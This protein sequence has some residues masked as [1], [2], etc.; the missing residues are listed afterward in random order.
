MEQERIIVVSTDT[1]YLDG[2]ESKLKKSVKREVETQIFD[3]IP[4]LNV[5]LENP[6]KA[7]VLLIDES[8]AREYA[9]KILAKKVLLLTETENRTE[10]IVS[11]YDGVHGIIRLMDAALL[12][13]ALRRI[14]ES[15]MV[16]HVVGLCG[17]CGKTTVS[18]G[19]SYALAARGRKVLYLNADTMQD[20]THEIG[21]HREDYATEA[22]AIAI[23]SS[24]SIHT[25]RFLEQMIH[26]AFDYPLP[27]RQNLLN[28]G[29]TEARMAE[30][31]YAVAKS[32]I[33]D[34]IVLEHPYGFT[35]GT[36]NAL[37]HA[38][39]VIFIGTQNEKSAER[40]ERIMKGNMTDRCVCSIVCNRFDKENE[41]ALTIAAEREGISVCEYIPE[42]DEAMPESLF[43]N[44]YFKSAAEIVSLKR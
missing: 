3:D 26:D 35:E 6:Q 34:D 20:Y 31:A 32:G 14:N 9:G 15:T 2:I 22:A 37:R 12:R 42:T 40:L 23:G 36:Q 21:K 28:Y 29:L 17:T 27:F 43:K 39:N 18:L 25:E 10:T 33:Y 8:L 44:G 4:A 24:G 5:F 13:D 30:T 7:A 1:E 19:L 11:K 16:I 41:D 38:D